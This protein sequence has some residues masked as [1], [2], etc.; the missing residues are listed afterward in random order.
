V[1]LGDELMADIDDFMMRHGYQNRSEA[2]RNL[3]R[4]GHDTPA[5]LQVTCRS[6]E[7]GKLIRTDAA[8]FAGRALP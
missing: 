2:I 1:R 7:N 6:V 8:S 5:L 4:A 3:A